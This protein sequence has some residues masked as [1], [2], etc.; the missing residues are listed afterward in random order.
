METRNKGI[1]LIPCLIASIT[2]G[3]GVKPIGIF[4]MT[5]EKL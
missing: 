5:K 4:A 1:A 2:K 3:I